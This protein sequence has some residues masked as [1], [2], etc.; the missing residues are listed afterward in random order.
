MLET[1]GRADRA[2]VDRA[3]AATK[4][5]KTA[6]DFTLLGGSLLA[7]DDLLRAESALRHAVDLDP[8]EFWAWFSLGHCH[9]EQNR[10]LDAAGDF[11]ACIALEPSFAWPRLNR[12]L[13]LARAG[14][15]IEA[16]EA[17]VQAIALNPRFAEAW[18]NRGLAELELDNLNAA[19]Q[20][21][22]KAL[23]CGTPSDP[24]V[25]A[26]WAEV[27]ARLGHRDEA[28]AR[29]NSLLQAHP[30]DP[31]LLTAGHLPARQRSQCRGSRPPARARPPASQPARRIMAWR[32]DCDQTTPRRPARRSTPRCATIRNSSTPARCAPSFSR[33][34][35]DLSAVDDVD[36]LVQV[37]SP[38]HLYNAAC[39]LSLLVTTAQADRF[40]NREVDLL[41][42]AIEAGF[43]VA[44]AAS[45]PDFQ[46][47]RKLPAFQRVLARA[48][49]AS[50]KSE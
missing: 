27:E 30:D 17:Y 40:G 29:F 35:G 28:E 50:S 13:A 2:A 12:G 11:A 26:A 18:L 45:D 38:H 4:T 44:Q 48:P 25:L 3:L 6:R 10:P 41:A 15:L 5:P 33:T 22:G 23:E 24:G 8:K 20:A 42:H 32:F 47:L 21:L 36:R 14:R 1:L 16:R 49:R 37:P 7:R 39:A 31:V 19:E 43:P 34:T 9:F 46:S